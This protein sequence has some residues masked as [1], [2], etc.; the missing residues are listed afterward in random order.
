MATLKE[1]NIKLGADTKELQANMRKAANDLRREARNFGQIGTELSLAVSLPLLGIGASALRAAG[2][3][4]AFKMG[5]NT[6]MKAAGRSA[7]DAAKEMEALRE[8]AKM[9]GIDF[10]QAIKGSMRLQGVGMSAE[11]ARKIMEEL[12][13]GIAMAGGTAQDFDGVTRQLAQ[14]SGKG[15]VL[16]EDLTILLENMPMLAKVLNDTFGTANAE[17]LR[18]MGVNAQDFIDGVTNGLSKLERVPGGLANSMVNFG[19]EVKMALA[20]VGESIN[21]A[22]NVTGKLEDFAGWISDAAARFSQLSEGTQK[23]IITTLG[24]TAAI[25]PAIKVFSI[26][27]NT[28]AAAIDLANKAVGAYKSLAGA[29][30]VAAEKF[31]AMDRV[32]KATTI[33]LIVAA[34]GLAVVAY[35][36]LTSKMSEAEKVQATL[37][38]V[39]QEAARSIAAE[40]VEA[41]RLIAVINDE[42][43]SRAQ[44]EAALK[45]LRQINADYFGDL[46]LEKSKV[47]DMNNAL[48]RYI[49]SIEKRAR[50]TAAN[51]KLVEIEK[52][53]LDTQQQFENA[54][55]DFWQQAGNALLNYGNTS[56]MVLA[57]VKDFTANLDENKKALEAQKAALLSVLKEGGGPIATA[58]DGAFTPTGK[59]GKKT[60]GKKKEEVD[61]MKELAAAMTTADAKAAALGTTFDATQAKTDAIR[62]A[63]ETLIGQGVTPSDERLSMLSERYKNL[64]ATLEPLP[65]MFNAVTGAMQ[66][67]TTVQDV[68]I[69]KTDAVSVA[70]QNMGAVIGNAALAASDAMLQM[71]AQGETSFKK[72]GK[73][74]LKGAADQVRAAMMTAVSSQIQKALVSVPFPFNLAIAGAAAAGVGVLFNKTLSALKIPAFGEGGMVNKPTLALIGEKGPE[75]VVPEKK[76][77]GLAVMQGLTRNNGGGGNMHLSGEFRVQ[78]TDLIL[79]LEKAQQQQYR[80]FGR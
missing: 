22:F 42:N 57:N 36:S 2:D 79:V 75:F 29:V 39:N 27:N 50:L 38:K 40:K 73:A 77:P 51:Q 1:L 18:E 63:I 37:N 28:K 11:K 35:Q 32:A 52:E 60:S 30:L 74:A 4:E 49:Q 76:L 62:N 12:A 23:A 21:K 45:R 19:V 68:F 14:M 70:F 72:L 58:S 65:G 44:K 67:S 47:E 17:K 78:G 31:A 34:I 43:A 26:W 71:A 61:A 33:G 41:E 69:E 13:N 54:K 59:P 5:F 48:G 25:G 66:L 6:T 3:I 80:S 64:T 20:T 53:L 56:G 16:Q 24:I 9:P 7:A 8:I 46:D 15:R 55:P 10:E